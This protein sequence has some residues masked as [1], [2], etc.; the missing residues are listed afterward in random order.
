MT[1]RVQP[2]A[3]DSLIR[4]DELSQIFN[5]FSEGWIVE[6]SPTVAAERR[7]SINET[8]LN[9][10][11]IVS[12]S[13]RDV[14]I[15]AGE[16]F[17]GGWCS[18]DTT[19]TISL[20]AE[21]TTTIVVGWD[22]DS[23]F[24]PATDPNRDAADE[25]IVDKQANTDPQYP[26]T[27]IFEFKTSGGKITQTIDKR[28]LGPTVTA[29]AID[30]ETA[31]IGEDNFD[32]SVSSIRESVNQLFIDNARQDFELGLTLLEM[33]EGQFEIYATD[34]DIVS[35]NNVV[36][37][38]GSPVNGNGTVKLKSSATDGFTEHAEEDFDLVP[39]S[40]LVTD[41]AV[42]VPDNATI[43]FEIEDEN[44]NIVTI[45]RDQLNTTVDVS[46]TLETFGNRTRAVLQRDSTSDTIP[47]LDAY[48][49][50]ISGAKPSTYLDTTLGTVKEV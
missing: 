29:E 5:Q 35:Q 14:T 4:N 42:A 28:R 38:L 6:N 8:A 44:G 33:Q 23:V 41:D 39:S 27:E 25:T 22:L 47:V 36:L 49:V 10:F 24:D 1:D 45:S 30:V 16:A 32:E 18:R 48:S 13:G 37:N 3:I 21:A 15:D 31:T 9:S 17:I 43:K 26:V 7:Q 2:G 12:T 20:P 46:G 50:F 11:S 34:D 19:T 40:V